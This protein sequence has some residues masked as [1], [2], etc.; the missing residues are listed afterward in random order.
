MC[1]YNKKTSKRSNT[2]KTTTEG[3]I[4]DPE[5]VVLFL[6]NGAGYKHTIPSGL[7]N[8]IMEN[9]K[10]LRYEQAQQSDLVEV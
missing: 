2:Y 8:E 7:Q 3:E 4:F 1:K 6:C 9:L 5:G 10:E